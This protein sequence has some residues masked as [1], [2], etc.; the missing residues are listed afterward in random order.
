LLQLITDK[1]FM[2]DLKLKELADKAISKLQRPFTPAGIWSM[3]REA[4]ALLKE[5]KP[6]DQTEHGIE[7]AMKKVKQLSND[8]AAIGRVMGDKNK[9]GGAVADAREELALGLARA[10]AL[11]TDREQEMIAA[12]KRSSVSRMRFILKKLKSHC[13]EAAGK[14]YWAIREALLINYYVENKGQAEDRDKEAAYLTTNYDQLLEQMRKKDTIF[15]P[16]VSAERDKKDPQKMIEMEI[17]EALP[18]DVVRYKLK[19]RKVVS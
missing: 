5:Y 9:T 4:N 10:R 14:A 11:K 17:G 18:R 13:E 7:A 3:V 15:V 1:I 6:D 8:L 2:R 12:L 16:V 19:T